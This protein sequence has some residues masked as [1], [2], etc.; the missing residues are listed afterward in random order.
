MNQGH[1]GSFSD[2]TATPYFSKLCHGHPCLLNAPYLNC[3]S[4]N[5]GTQ[6]FELPHNG[7]LTLFL[8]DCH[9]L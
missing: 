6:N 2:V 3:R 1:F 4:K 8:D 5:R 9:A 7:L